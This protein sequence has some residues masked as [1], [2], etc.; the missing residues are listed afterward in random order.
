MLPPPPRIA[1]SSVRDL[2]PDLTVNHNPNT[3]RNKH[4]GRHWLNY[5][6]TRGGSLQAR[7]LKGRS[8]SPKDREQRWGCRPPTSGFR[9]FKALCLW[10][11]NSVSRLQH[12]STPSV[13]KRNDRMTAKDYIFTK[14]YA[15]RKMYSNINCTEWWIPAKRCRISTVRHRICY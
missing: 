13:D 9:A 15:Q 12:L 10:H 1:I 5:S 3:Y 7:G 6:A 11:L 4:V 8:S 14:R 2:D